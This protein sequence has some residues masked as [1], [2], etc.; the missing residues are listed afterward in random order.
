MHNISVNKISPYSK[1]SNINLNLCSIIFLFNQ[2]NQVLLQLRDNKP[3]ILDPNVWGP[4]GGHCELNET[5]FNCASRELHEETGY[6][7]SKLNWYRNFLLPY[8]DNT[9]HVVCT[10]WAIYDNVQKIR[11]YEGQKIVF[12]SIEKLNKYQIS[13]KNISIINKIKEIT[14][15]YE[16]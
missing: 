16:Q 9:N 5:P 1:I 2:K 14:N 4:L 11:C 8:R 15:K 13:K 6:I 7:S 3:E 12:L 10:F